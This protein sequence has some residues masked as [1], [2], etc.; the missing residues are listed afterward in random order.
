MK[1][2]L[3]VVFLTLCSPAASIAQDRSVDTDYEVL[4]FGYMFQYISSDLK[5]YKQPNWRA[6]YPLTLDGSVLT[7][8][9]NSIRSRPKPGFGLG[10]L[11]SLRMTDHSSLRFNPGL[12]FTDRLVEYEYASN[13]PG[14][15]PPSPIVKR[16]V[17]AT[18]VDLPLS[19]KL[20]SDLNGRFRT[21]LLGGGRFS[22]SIL[23]KKKL[24]D[25]ALAPQEKFL[26]NKDSFFSYEAGVGI[27][28]YFEY[29]KLSPEIKY[30][31]SI[32]NVLQRANSPYATPLDK[33]FLHS[34]Q[35]SL[36]F[37]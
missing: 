12:A 33:L 32:G 15:N 7:D 10:F 22:K 30:S 1:R 18:T 31:H 24:D 3:T 29:F 5:I 13:V 19:Y 8:E 28:F 35:V 9:L 37:Q 27:D 6:P 23:S 2:A 26:K 34:I 36:F 20:R 21:Y 14:S 25:S 4:T 11:A 17:Q 16:I